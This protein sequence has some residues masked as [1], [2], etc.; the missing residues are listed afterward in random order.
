[1]ERP[2]AEGTILQAEGYEQNIPL[3]LTRQPAGRVHSVFQ[4]GVNIRMGKKLFFIGT[5]KNGQLP[6]GIHLAQNQL[7]ELLEVI[8]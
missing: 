8:K 4:N 6:F 2:S 1:M 7:Q 5:T 3:L